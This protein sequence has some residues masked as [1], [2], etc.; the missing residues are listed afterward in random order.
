MS[1]QEISTQ[2]AHCEHDADHVSV[3]RQP[4]VT[5][6]LNTPSIDVTEGKLVTALEPNTLVGSGS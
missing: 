3:T 4:W 5:P 6:R 2:G 1:N